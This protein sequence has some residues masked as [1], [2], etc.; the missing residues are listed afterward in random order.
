LVEG[1]SRFKIQD[2]RFKG[3]QLPVCCPSA[4]AGGS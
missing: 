3:K 2:S 4:Q 1:N